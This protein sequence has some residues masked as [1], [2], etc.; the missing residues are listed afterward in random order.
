MRKQYHFKLT[1]KGMDAWDVHRLIE[2]S[3][4]LQTKNIPLS[5]IKELDE[6]YWYQEIPGKILTCKEIAKHCKLIIEADLNYP[7]ILSS[8]GSVMDGMHRVCKSLLEE[9]KT[10]NVKQFKVDPEPTYINVENIKEL[11]Y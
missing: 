1:E 4:N 11:P 8:S 2:L 6:N 5:I 9:R 3:K 10:I 7:I